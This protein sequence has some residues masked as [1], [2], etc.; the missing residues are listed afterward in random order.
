[1]NILSLLARKEV[2]IG[3]A[4]V[5]VGVAIWAYGNS[6]YDKGKSDERSDWMTK[7][8]TEPVKTMVKIE[9]VW[10]P[11]PV[12][13]MKGK[14][15]MTDGPANMHPLDSTNPCA[16]WQEVQTVTF[17]D[18]LKGRHDIAYYPQDKTFTEDYIPP[19]VP[20]QTKTITERQEIPL[21]VEHNWWITLTPSFTKGSVGVGGFLGYKALGV[22]YLKIMD[23]DI[24]QAGLHIDF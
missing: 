6:R 20:I 15:Y 22:G 8:A 24:Y 23:A 1:M 13:H 3:I 17:H 14:V 21:L 10:V 11:Q 5:A 9:T 18:S 19:F 4:V 16:E 12:Q 7:I 2:W